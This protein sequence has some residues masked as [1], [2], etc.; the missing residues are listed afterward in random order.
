MP[1]SS[2]EISFSHNNGIESEMQYDIFRI[3]SSSSSG[4]LSCRQRHYIRSKIA[5][6]TKS[7]TD[8]FA[9]SVE[10]EYDHFDRFYEADDKN[11][12]YSDAYMIYIM[13]L[14]YNKCNISK[15]VKTTYD[16]KCKNFILATIR[17]QRQHLTP[18]VQKRSRKPLYRK[19]SMF[20]LSSPDLRCLLLT[21]MKEYNRY[22]M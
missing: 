13:F 11:W 17:R 5:Q 8:R 1:P 9:H 22:D 18:Y 16:M 2:H 20:E 6:F 19:I 12:Q 4:N 15:W 7:M 14:I 10:N 3:C 21:I